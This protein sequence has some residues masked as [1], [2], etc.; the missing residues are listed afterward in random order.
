MSAP[1]RKIPVSLAP[2]NY[3]ADAQDNR[4]GTQSIKRSKSSLWHSLR[5]LSWRHSAGDRMAWSTTRAIWSPRRTRQLWPKPEGEPTLRQQRHPFAPRITS[6]SAPPPAW[7]PRRRAAGIKATP[8]TVEELQQR[9]EQCRVEAGEA[10][11]PPKPTL[12]VSLGQMLRTMDARATDDLMKRWDASGKGEIRKA[13]MRVNLR[14][15]NFEVSS[16]D[17]D[18]LFDSWDE[19]GDGTLDFGELKEAFSKMQVEAAAFDER[20]A[21]GISERDRILE[22]AALFDQAAAETARAIELETALEDFSRSLRSRGDVMLGELLQRR[23]VSPG[24]VVITWA[25][26]KGDNEGELS[27]VRARPRSLRR[28]VEPPLASRASADAVTLPPPIRWTGR[29]SPSRAE[30]LCRLQGDG[31]GGGQ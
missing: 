9:A 17:A 20:P 10:P 5:S 2:A 1:I 21:E 14:K 22:Q 13:G 8:P 26:S 24:E 25:S 18:A 31:D 15:C 27:K 19:S 12:R 16:K 6:Y 7:R 30:P 29:L 11:P 23:K 3:S 28:S 4:Q